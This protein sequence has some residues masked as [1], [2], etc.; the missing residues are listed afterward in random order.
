MR[1]TLAESEIYLRFMPTTY[2]DQRHLCRKEAVFPF[3]NQGPSVRS[4]PSDP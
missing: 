2:L 4:R 1:H 3:H